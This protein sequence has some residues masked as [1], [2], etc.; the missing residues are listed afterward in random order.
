VCTFIIIL[1]YQLLSIIIDY[2]QCTLLVNYSC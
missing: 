1:Q 2:F